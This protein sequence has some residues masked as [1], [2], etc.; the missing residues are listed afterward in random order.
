MR[1]PENSEKSKFDLFHDYVFL[2]IDPDSDRETNKRSIREAAVDFAS[3]ELGVDESP[4]AYYATYF[5]KLLQKE[6]EK[7][8]NV[9]ELLYE[10]SQNAEK[11]EVVLRIFN[12]LSELNEGDL[13]YLWIVVHGIIRGDYFVSTVLTDNYSNRA[14]SIGLTPLET[15]KQ[16]NTNSK[17]RESL[18]SVKKLIQGRIIQPDPPDIRLEDVEGFDEYEK[19]IFRE[20][21]F[22]LRQ[23]VD[24]LLF[25]SIESDKIEKILDKTKSFIHGFVYAKGFTDESQKFKYKKFIDKVTKEYFEQLKKY[26][27]E[28]SKPERKNTFF[29]DILNEPYLINNELLCNDTQKSLLEHIS[30]NWIELREKLILYLKNKEA[31]IEKYDAENSKERPKKPQT[32]FFTKFSGT[33]SS[34]NDAATAETVKAEVIEDQLVADP[35]DFS[36]S[37]TE[38]SLTSFGIPQVTD[39]IH[40][41]TQTGDMDP[42]ILEKGKGTLVWIP[43][44]ETPSEITSGTA[45]KTDETIRLNSTAGIKALT[46]E[47]L[48]RYK[49]ENNSVKEELKENDI[50][51]NFDL[52][53]KAEKLF[54][55]VNRLYDRETVQQLKQIIKEEILPKLE[56]EDFKKEFMLILL[57]KLNESFYKAPDV[58]FTQFRILIKEILNILVADNDS[59]IPENDFIESVKEDVP[60]LDEYPELAEHLKNKGYYQYFVDIQNKLKD[61]VTDFADRLTIHSELIKKLNGQP[62]YK[63][64][65]NDYGK[66]KENELFKLKQESK[67]VKGNW[68]TGPFIKMCRSLRG[69][70]KVSTQANEYFE[71]LSNAIDNIWEEGMYPV[72]N[73]FSKLYFGTHIEL[74][75]NTK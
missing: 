72:L 8:Q 70:N 43:V 48:T 16:H 66:D 31:F 62:Y 50:N 4:A 35:D 26:A 39:Y 53:F 3:T 34:F 60:E 40:H 22:L 20:I 54:K 6:P 23:T 36:R 21:Y 44:Q 68:F 38:K 17:R 51:G 58:D 30:K 67:K 45:E 71:E 33:G 49:A 19:N 14:H 7:Y 69:N 61:L 28:M 37:Q 12:K 59:Y 74:Q 25:A 5:F 1:S 24:A 10:L 32:Q 11:A 63:D 9:W 65:F 73:N 56:S 18:E 29:Q 13:T 15:R 2:T 75:S 46:E 52:R 27:V 47:E 42:K 55:T 57:E 64:I 41:P